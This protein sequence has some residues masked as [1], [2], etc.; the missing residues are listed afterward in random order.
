M[1]VVNATIEATADTIDAMRAA[2]AEMEAASRAEEGCYDYTF[3]VEL[4]NPNVMRITEQWESM[5]HLGAH[6]AT[7]HMAA[8]QA[9][10]GANP[11]KSVEAKFYEANEVSPPGA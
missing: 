10:M 11:P 1:I 3:S 8:F 9:A 7:P 2:I 6:F 4:N 5:E